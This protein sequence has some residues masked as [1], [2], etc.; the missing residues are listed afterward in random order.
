[1]QRWLEE[2]A[3]FPGAHHQCPSVLA[4]VG[5]IK[6]AADDWPDERMGELVQRYGRTDGFYPCGGSRPRFCHRAW[7]HGLIGGHRRLS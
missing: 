4:D 6:V 3:G 2:S 5:Q 7:L 1:M